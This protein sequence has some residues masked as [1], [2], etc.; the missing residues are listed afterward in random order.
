MFNK[1]FILGVFSIYRSKDGQY[2]FCFNSRK[3][4]PLFTSSKF[5]L[6]FECEDAVRVLQEAVGLLTFETTK[7]SDGS[8]TLV[9]QFETFLIKSRKFTTAFRQ[10]KAVDELKRTAAKAEVLDFS[11]ALDV[12]PE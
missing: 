11:S 5:E 9:C 3:G 7:N 6:R 4:K 10:Q 8:V 12:F 1:L 2:R